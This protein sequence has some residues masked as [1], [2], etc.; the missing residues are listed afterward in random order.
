MTPRWTL[1]YHEFVT[2]I[3]LRPYFQGYLFSC[4]ANWDIIQT[5]K[6]F[7]LSPAKITAWYQLEFELCQVLGVLV[8]YQRGYVVDVPPAPS[9]FGYMR[10][11][12]KERFAC[13]QAIISRDWFVVLA[14]AVAYMA[15]V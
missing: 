2:M 3:P 13:R 7:Q 5:P 12:A 11:H 4:L 6:G 8:G 9:S 14:S 1:A 10:P 15:R